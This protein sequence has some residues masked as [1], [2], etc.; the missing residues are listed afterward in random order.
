VDSIFFHDKKI[1]KNG[2]PEMSE[3]ESYFGPLGA[4]LIAHKYNLKNG[5]KFMIS[6]LKKSSDPIHREILDVFHWETSVH[7]QLK[8]NREIPKYVHPW[9]FSETRY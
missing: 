6:D 1:A 2:Y 8:I 7:K 3:S 9:K 4:L 5:L